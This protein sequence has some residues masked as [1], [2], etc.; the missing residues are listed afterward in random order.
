MRVFVI[1]LLIL[2]GVV[3]GQR[4]KFEINGSVEG[5]P[6]GSLVFL[7][8]ANNPTDTVSRDI[9]KEGKFKLSGKVKEP[10]LYYLNFG[11]KK[12]DLLFVGNDELK[13]S[14]N[15]DNIK[16]LVVSGSPSHEDFILFQKTF[17]PLFQQYTQ[18]NQQLRTNGVTDSLSRMVNNTYNTI[19]KQLDE[20]INTHKSSYVSAFALVVTS[21]INDNPLLLENRYNLL[22]EN[23]RK[24]YFGTYLKSTIDDDKIGA[25]GT[26]A[27]D[28]TQND[29]DGKPFQFSSLKGKYVLIDFWASW[30]GPCRMENPNVVMAYNKFKSKNFT[31]LGVSLDR[32]RE[33]WLKAIADDQLSWTQVSDLK[34]W[35]NEVAVKYKIQSIPQNYLVAPDGKIVAKNLRGPALESKLC[36][37]LGCN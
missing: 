1:L 4:E 25:V 20:F 12:K 23:V 24:G 9:S 26:D 18:L 10:N 6:S 2:P 27:I 21:Q 19:H 16:S 28:F 29:V 5:L 3:F 34:F 11:A 7:T 36:E 14:G 13:V 30:C 15:V 22:D 31:I 33:P 32:A 17:N 37:L 8:D 35:N